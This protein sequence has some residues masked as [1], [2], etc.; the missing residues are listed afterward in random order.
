[1]QARFPYRTD[2]D[3]FLVVHERRQNLSPGHEAVSLADAVTA[4]LQAGHPAGPLERR[5]CARTKRRRSRPLAGPGS[6]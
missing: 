5:V 6:G 3:L 4:A 2:G 1:M